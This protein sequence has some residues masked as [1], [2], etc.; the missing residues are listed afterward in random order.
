ML[1]QNSF[2]LRGPSVGLT[3]IKSLKTQT[4]LEELEI[5]YQNEIYICISGYSKKLLISG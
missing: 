4:N 2:I 3:I 5:I 1:F